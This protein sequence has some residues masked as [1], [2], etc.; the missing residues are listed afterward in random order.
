MDIFHKYD[1]FLFYLFY[2]LFFIILV[3]GIR[4]QSH[5][6]KYYI[7]LSFLLENNSRVE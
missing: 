7:L 2:F 3:G 6:E 4:D 1:S 5:E